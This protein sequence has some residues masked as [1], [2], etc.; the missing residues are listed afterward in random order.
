MTSTYTATNIQSLRKGENMSSQFIDEL[1]MNIFI[2][3]RL[4][5]QQSEVE[6]PTWP[7]AINSLSFR[8]ATCCHLYALLKIKQGSTPQSKEKLRNQF[9]DLNHIAYATLFE[10]ILSFET[11]VKYIYRNAKILLKIF[12]DNV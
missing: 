11:E 9:I 5:Y 1:A 3:T 4:L 8:Y 2:S 10:G 12:S 7:C 6:P